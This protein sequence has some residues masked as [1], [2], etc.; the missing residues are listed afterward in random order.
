MLFAFLTL[1]INPLTNHPFS[2]PSLLSLLFAAGS[3]ALI[4]LF[5]RAI[6]DFCGGLADWLTQVDGS[7]E[8]PSEKPSQLKPVSLATLPIQAAVDDFIEL[9]PTSNL[10]ANARVFSL[11]RLP[12]P[13]VRPTIARLS[14]QYRGLVV[15]AKA[16]LQTSRKVQPKEPQSAAHT[17][18]V[19][20]LAEVLAIFEKL[21]L[22]A[23]Q[24][25]PAE[26]VIVE[27]LAPAHPN[28]LWV[29]LQ[30]HIAR[31]AGFWRL[32]RHYVVDASSRAGTIAKTAER[33]TN[34]I[35]HTVAASFVQAM[36]TAYRL[37]YHG[38]L[39][40][41][42]GI[43]LV[44]GRIFHGLH[45]ASNMT[46]RAITLA[47]RRALQL[48][49]LCAVTIT[50]AMLATGRAI[51][52]AWRAIGRT[53]AMLCRAIYRVLATGVMLLFLGAGYSL[54]VFSLACFMVWELFE[55]YARRMDKWLGNAVDEREGLSELS[56]MGREM[57][58]TFTQWYRQLRDIKHS[59][60]H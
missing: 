42:L 15:R 18:V 12:L 33:Q 58:R 25:Q 26:A 40:A 10:T 37:A 13:E 47:Y 45:V 50:L 1:G 27:P 30:R 55:P 8:A 41:A 39:L 46:S 23:E 60:Y 19:P 16:Q 24:A 14:R 38:I 43:L 36:R 6:S 44:A 9:K 21:A 48:F 7:F 17:D 49:V 28:V 5:S 35:G 3:I 32:I 57:T 29:A 59:I 20:E 31:L 34:S 56:K 52:T 51:N 11:P 4:L 2:T 54:F 53:L 22:E